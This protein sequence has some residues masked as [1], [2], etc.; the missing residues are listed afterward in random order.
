MI[1]EQ[2][3]RDGSLRAELEPTIA[4]DLL[5]ALRSLRTWEDLVLVR[6]WTAAQYEERLVATLLRVLTK[7]SPPDTSSVSKR[8][9]AVRS[10]RR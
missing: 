4:A 7:T 2:L 6:G 3:A 1:V 8:R 9:D 5:W 10:Q